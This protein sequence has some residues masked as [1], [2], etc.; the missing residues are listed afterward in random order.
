MSKT[1]TCVATVTKNCEISIPKIIYSRFNVEALKKIKNIGFFCDLKAK[2]IISLVRRNSM[3]VKIGGSVL[4]Y[5]YNKTK[6]SAGC[7]CWLHKNT[8]LV[9]NL[10]H[11]DLVQIAAEYDENGEGQIVIEKCEDYEEAKHGN[12]WSNH[13]LQ[14]DDD[15]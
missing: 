5:C 2:K 15:Y 9:L 6:M 8:A 11:K 4:V 13:R 7:L 3:C 10:K 1:I 14:W 12:N